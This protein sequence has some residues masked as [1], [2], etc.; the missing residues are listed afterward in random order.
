MTDMVVT[1]RKRRMALAA[2][3]ALAIYVV[4]PLAVSGHDHSHDLSE[5]CGLCILATTASA[6]FPPQHPLPHTCEGLQLLPALED[7]AA[8]IDLVAERPARAPPVA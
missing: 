2:M 1:A 7:A 8:S 6:D 5:E 3:L 4:A